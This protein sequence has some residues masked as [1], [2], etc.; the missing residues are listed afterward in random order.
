MKRLNAGRFVLCALILLSGCQT[1]TPTDSRRI[2]RIQPYEVAG[3]GEYYAL[4]DAEVHVGVENPGRSPIAKNA[5]SVN[6]SSRSLD[7]G[8]IEIVVS[9][10]ERSGQNLIVRANG[11]HDTVIA[12]SDLPVFQAP[13]S[14]AEPIQPS[15]VRLYGDTT[16]IR[17]SDRQDRILKIDAQ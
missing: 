14:A 13:S 7:R 11:F 9:G 2:I 15:R 1:R 3:P 8:I 4:L 10:P 6:W 12:L 17:L 16:Y 5:G